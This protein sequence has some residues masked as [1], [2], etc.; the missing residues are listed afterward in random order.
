MTVHSSGEGEASARVRAAVRRAI[1][2][3]ALL[4]PGDV[5][6][7]GVSG[8][9]DSLCL[10]H[11][12][13]NLAAGCDAR[14]HVGHLHH[15]LRGADA[16]ADAAFVEKL[17]RDWGVD[18]TVERADVRA[19]ARRRHLTIEEAA[20]Q[21]RY[22]F[23]ARLAHRVGADTVAVA[24]NADDQVE[25]VLM[26]LL[27]GSGLAG[28]RG[29]LPVSRLAA[30]CLEGAEDEQASAAALRLVRPLLAVP[31]AD[32]EA[33][34]R[35]QGL[36]PRFDLSN[37]DQTY[38]RN[39][40]RHELVPLLETYNPAVRQ[41]LTRTAEV[42]AGDYELLR[43]QLDVAWERVVRSATGEAVVYDLAGLRAAPLAVQRSL[44]RR[45]VERLRRSLRNIALVHIE[46]ALDVLREGHAGAA[47]TLPGGLLLRLGYDDA[48]LAGVAY[49]RP[50]GSE[51]RLGFEP[52][53]VPLPG[54]VTLPD[55]RWRVVTRL[56]DRGTLPVDWAL[57]CDRY[58]AYLTA[59]KLDAP[60]ALRGR[61][62]GDW[63]RPL[64]MGGRQTVHAAMVNWKVPRAER[65]RVPLLTC[66]DSIVWVVGY[67]LDERY[68]V[69]D[70]TTQVAVIQCERLADARDEQVAGA[71]PGT[72]KGDE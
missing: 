28:L 39:R 24:H 4:L 61:R 27:R 44:L 12:W 5:V 71:T 11:L 37:L 60:L 15:G 46:N 36:A 2:R 1:A 21:A 18:C 23:L 22:A 14:L 35:E 3:H 48:T 19:L 49:E 45:G 17:C 62:S 40:L 26:H 7:L 25:T 55:E 59:D 52:L 16:D 53:Q 30:L 54:S 43:E 51:P 66:G 33:Y 10:L 32:I 8:G 38:Y 63:F 67:R 41:V 9:P 34:C 50:D 65:A 42:L 64:G 57:N 47:A 70:A 58:R 31:R 68:A 6:V 13:R 29:M 20:R 72:V 69:G 56:V